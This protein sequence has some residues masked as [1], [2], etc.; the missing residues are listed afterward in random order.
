MI[1]VKECIKRR[2]RHVAASSKSMKNPAYL[3][4]SNLFTETPNGVRTT[5]I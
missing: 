4:F 1:Y 3:T 5:T 2:G